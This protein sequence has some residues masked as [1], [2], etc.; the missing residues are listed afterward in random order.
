MGR[1]QNIADYKPKLGDRI[2]VDTN[3][4]ISQ[5][6]PVN[7]GNSNKYQKIWENITIS[8]D[9][10]LI[11]SSIQISEF[12][13]RCIRMQFEIYKHEH[14]SESEFKFKA[15]YRETSDYKQSITAILEIVKSDILPQFICVDDKFDM[16]DKNKL[17][18]EGFS[19]DFNDAMLAE[20]AKRE[21][22]YLLTDDGDFVNFIHDLEIITGNSVLLMFGQ[23]QK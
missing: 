22:A 6:W 17:F 20:I 1:A 5:L 14:P 18:S 19:Y 2:V 21:K 16:M 12:V 3:I 15:H 7:G 10:A 11:L 13:N 23:S 8:K 4:L 9:V